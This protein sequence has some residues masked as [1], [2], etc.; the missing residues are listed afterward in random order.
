MNS[1]FVDDFERAVESE[2]INLSEYSKSMKNFRDKFIAHR[3]EYEQ[4]KPIPCLD[5]ALIVCDMFEKTVL[6]GELVVLEIGVMDFY[7]RSIRE[8]SE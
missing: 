2:G 3:D 6:Q 7:Q 4:R 5:H 1:A 8:I